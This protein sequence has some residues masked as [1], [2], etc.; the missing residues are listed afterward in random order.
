MRRGDK[1]LEELENET[2]EGQKE[3]RADRNPMPPWRWAVEKIASLPCGLSFTCVRAVSAPRAA[4]PSRFTQVPLVA[5][6]NVS[7]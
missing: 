2:L 3:S 6:V 1:V 5:P 4:S 7:L